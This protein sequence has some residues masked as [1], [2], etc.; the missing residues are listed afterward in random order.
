MQSTDHLPTERV[1]KYLHFFWDLHS[2]GVDKWVNIKV[3]CVDQDREMRGIMQTQSTWTR[4]HSGE[5]VCA[6]VCVCVF[7]CVCVLVRGVILDLNLKECV[8][9]IQVKESYNITEKI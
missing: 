2:N 1:K 3:G 8:G 6:C 9:V 5:G 4:F 7:V